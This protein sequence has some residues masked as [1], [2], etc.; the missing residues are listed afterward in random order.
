[1]FGYR[2]PFKPVAQA[3]M[4][5]ELSGGTFGRDEPKPRVSSCGYVNCNA[6]KAADAGDEN[7]RPSP[8][9]LTDDNLQHFVVCPKCQSVA[10]CSE[11]CRQADATVP[12]YNFW[13]GT[14]NVHKAICGPYKKNT[15]LPYVCKALRDY[16][17]KFDRY[18][19]P[20]GF[21]VDSKA[22]GSKKRAA[23][24]AGTNKKQKSVDSSAM[25]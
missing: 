13:D 3:R 24:V 19:H 5:K 14:T 18:P 25:A 22:T 16:H 12:T 1:M 6:N 11:A 8:V 17:A 21:D 10:Y 20:L 15:K 23:T 4:E 7:K 9:P 2:G